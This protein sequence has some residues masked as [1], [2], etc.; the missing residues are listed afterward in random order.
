MEKS[1]KK[2]LVLGIG[3]GAIRTINYIVSNKSKNIDADFLCIDT[4]KEDLKNAKAKKLQIG[5]DITKGLNS[6]GD[7]LKGVYAIYENEEDIIRILNKYEIVFVINCLGGGTGSGAA[8]AVVKLIK[9][10][11]LRAFCI[12]TKP[13]EYQIKAPNI[14]TNAIIDKLKYYCDVLSTVDI[15]TQLKLIV[16]E[17]MNKKILERFVDIYEKEILKIRK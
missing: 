11:R 3:G 7:P 9:D 13:F 2:V 17:L 8:V 1:D 15:E 16:F 12:A 14:P 6:D 10:L 4:D 5:K